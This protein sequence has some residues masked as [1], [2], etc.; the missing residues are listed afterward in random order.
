VFANLPADV[1]ALAIATPTPIASQDPDGQSQRLL[2]TRTDDVDAFREGDEEEAFHPK[3]TGTDDVGEIVKTVL[4][5]RIAS[6]FGVQFN[7]GT[8]QRNNMDEARDHVA[9]ADKVLV[10]GTSLTVYPAAGLVD[11]A[12]H[13][14]ER[15]LNVLEIDEVPAGFEFRPGRATVIVPEI[16]ARWLESAPLR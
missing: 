2:G 9:S 12:R 10:V 1:E 7:Q 13:D 5:A 16:T 4:N 14:A 8:F 6:E 11:A 15:V 3:A